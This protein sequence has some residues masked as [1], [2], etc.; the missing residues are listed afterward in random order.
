MAHA[1]V[2]LRPCHGV[3]ATLLCLACRLLLLPPTGQCC[4]Q[5]GWCGVTSGH[6]GAG[7]QRSFGTCWAAARLP[8]SARA[9]TLAGALARGF[10]VT[11]AP[12]GVETAVDGS[13]VSR[14]AASLAST[15][16][17]VSSVITTEIPAHPARE[18]PTIA[19]AAAVALERGA[20]PAATSVDPAI[21][22]TAASVVTPT[23]AASDPVAAQDPA[24][25][26]K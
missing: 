23:A 8:R 4:S 9:G 18:D 22:A 3:T 25:A 21:A 14:S 26:G 17:F 5:W 19:P 20:D 15:E 11:G 13:P 2:A 1:I 7:C 6:C 10:N 16:P 24:V 12:A